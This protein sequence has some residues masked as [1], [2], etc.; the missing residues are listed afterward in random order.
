MLKG[1]KDPTGAKPGLGRFCLAVEGGE[2]MGG[3]DEGAQA[4]QTLVSNSTSER[5]ERCGMG[6][7]Q[8]HRVAAGRRRC[9]SGRPGGGELMEMVTILEIILP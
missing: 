5:L 1:R 9:K 2:Q 7:R 6:N 8:P 3:W 4:V